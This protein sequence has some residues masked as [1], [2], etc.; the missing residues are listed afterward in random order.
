MQIPTDVA[1]A[2]PTALLI[3]NGDRV[4]VPTIS[5]GDILVMIRKLGE[6]PLLEVKNER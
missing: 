5:R 2:L 1:L 3:D 4:R 6:H